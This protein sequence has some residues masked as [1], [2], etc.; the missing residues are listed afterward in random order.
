MS[1]TPLPEA[2]TLVVKPDC[3]LCA[4]ARRLASSISAEFG[5][6][7]LEQSILDEH[8]RLRPDYAK[9]AE[10][11]PVLLIDGVQRDFWTIDPERMRRLLRDRQ[12]RPKND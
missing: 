7:V 2:V 9:F 1:P 12:S 5:L 10:E 8:G 3:H 4:E 6:S 11:V